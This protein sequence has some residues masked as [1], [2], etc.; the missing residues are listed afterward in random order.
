MPKILKSNLS[1]SVRRD[2]SDCPRIRKYEPY[3]GFQ[4]PQGGRSN[5]NG[6][7]GTGNLGSMEKMATTNGPNQ[8]KQQN[9][10]FI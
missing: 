2:G 4:S 7:V 8:Q 10:K 9:P 6:L 1:E 3:F 5:S